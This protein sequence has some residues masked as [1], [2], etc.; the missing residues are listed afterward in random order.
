MDQL[1]P[2]YGF[3]EPI[4]RL[5]FRSTLYLLEFL[6]NLCGLKR[7]NFVAARTDDCD[8]PIFSDNR[9]EDFREDAYNRASLSR[10]ASSER[11]RHIFSRSF[12][13]NEKPVFWNFITS[14]YILH[15]KG[16]EI[17]ATR[18]LNFLRHFL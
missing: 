1:H 3:T 18:L 2:T 10:N 7:S 15:F 12:F 13:F 14:R 5:Y 16:P 4:R 8:T 9:L 17:V 6:S 11:T